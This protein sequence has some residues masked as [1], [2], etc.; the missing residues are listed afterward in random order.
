MRVVFSFAQKREYRDERCWLFFRLMLSAILVSY[1]GVQTYH[2]ACAISTFNVNTNSVEDETL[3][4][5]AL[6]SIE[7]EFFSFF[8]IN[9]IFSCKVR[10][11]TH[12][13]GQLIIQLI[14]RYLQESSSK[15]NNT[16]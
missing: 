14:Y 11:H 3:F 2:Y 7:K 12:Y 10:I 13:I 16:T 5:F 9:I 15:I 8:E 4:F 6:F 1:R